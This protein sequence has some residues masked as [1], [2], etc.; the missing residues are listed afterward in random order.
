M[1][2]SRLIASLLLLTACERNIFAQQ[3]NPYASHQ[4]IEFKLGLLNFKKSLELIPSGDSVSKSHLNVTPG[5]Y[6]SIMQGLKISEPLD[7]RHHY[8]TVLFLDKDLH[9]DSIIRYENILG[10]GVYTVKWSVMHYNLYL[11]KDDIFSP[12]DDYSTIVQAIYCNDNNLLARQFIKVSKKPL[13]WLP[14]S[15]QTKDPWIFPLKH[16]LTKKLETH[17]IL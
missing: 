11:K 12:A 14:I 9:T 15:D 6:D 16:E 17:K 3:S 10:F 5:L 1:P 7:R 8:V 2:F 4:V 13:T